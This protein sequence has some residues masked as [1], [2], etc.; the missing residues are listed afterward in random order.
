MPLFE[1]LSIVGLVVATLLPWLTGTLAA[2][3]IVGNAPSALL[4]GHGY[5]LG[6]L[7]IVLLLLAWDQLGLQL[8][9]WPLC[10]TLALLTLGLGLCHRSPPVNV[11]RNPLPGLS[12][13]DLAWAV[14]L[15]GFVWLRWG[16]LLEQL[17]LLPLFPWDAWMN[18]VP[19]AVV[20]FEHRELT[21]F[22]PPAAWLAT[23]NS[24]ELYTLG[25]DQASDYP[26]AIPLLLLWQMLGANT[27]DHTLLYLPW[28]VMPAAGA[29]AMWGHLRCLQL[30]RPLSTLAIYLVLSIPLLNTHAV[31]AG[32]ADLWLGITFALGSMALAHWQHCGQ[33]RF[34][35]LT[36]TAALFCALLKNPGTGFALMLLAALPLV[37]LPGWRR[38]VFLLLVPALLLLLAGLLAGLNPEWVERFDSLGTLQLPAHLPRLKLQLSPLL[39]YLAESFY[40]KA[41]WHLLGVLV[42]LVLLGRVWM[43][44]WRSTDCVA[45]L[46]LLLGA[47]TLMAV[48]GFTHY[49]DAVPDGITVHRAFLYIVP[50]AVFACFARLPSMLEAGPETDRTA[51]DSD[52]SKNIADKSALDGPGSWAKVVIDRV[53]AAI[54]LVLLLPFLLTIALLIRLTSPGPVVFHQARHGL[55]HRVIQVLKF[56][57][58]YH[59]DLPDNRQ[60]TRNDPR[61]TPIG[62]WLRR[63]SL[64]EL[65]QLINVLRGEMS[66]VGPRPHPVDM[67]QR[68]ADALDAYMQR[69]RVRPG[70]T[71]WAQV[72]GHRGETD[73]L[74]K[75]QL[76][77]HYDLDYINH[78]SL[79]L[80]M[81]ILLRTLLV[82]WR[83]PNAY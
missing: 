73:T 15:S 3:L 11:T 35:L 38:R 52:V 83:G 80:D 17:T 28:L 69:H 46:L 78:W 63:T 16:N 1:E 55:D 62:R 26:P 56:R 72:H 60:A 64:D 27:S 59:Q 57:T 6:Q 71:G 22:A 54:L 2:R 43:R 36:V 75:M 30:S 34:A 32:Y 65:P 25:N 10:G 7:L 12:W 79:A 4:L 74:E 14:P 24:A 9:W 37:A 29:L 76:R 45:V 39:L 47:S 18:W 70:I 67:N 5:L 51:P 20:W 19:K 66:L 44:G 41:N 68:W 81:R 58:M 50:L 40:L 61:I 53:V 31:L 48:F 8:S 23:S 21:P 42:P 13:R 77:L 49:A 33:A 82:G